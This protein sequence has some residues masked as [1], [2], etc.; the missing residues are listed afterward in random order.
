MN[1]KEYTVFQKKLTLLSLFFA[2]YFF[3]VYHFPNN[4]VI[5]KKIKIILPWTEVLSWRDTLLL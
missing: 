1:N 3:F 4:E 5:S 2:H